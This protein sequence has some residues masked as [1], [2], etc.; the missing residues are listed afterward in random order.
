MTKLN[1]KVL[2]SCLQTLIENCL[3]EG[4]T[5]ENRRIRNNATNNLLRRFRLRLTF[6][7]FTKNIRQLKQERMKHFD[8]EKRAQDRVLLLE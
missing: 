8:R 3:P 2:R 6:T 7:K 4:E 1:R 5:L